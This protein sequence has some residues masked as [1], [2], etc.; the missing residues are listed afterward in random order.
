M[1]ISILEFDEITS[2]SDYLKTNHASLG[3][4]TFVRAQH[5]TSGRGQFKR[6]WE[7]EKGSNLL[8]SV[9]LKP[10]ENVDIHDI[11]NHVL[12]GLLNVLEHHGIM[13]RY[14]APN[15]LYVEHKKI[16]GILIE[17][18]MHGSKPTY[19]VVGIGL[20]VNQ[21][22]F[23]VPNATSMA[24]LKSRTFDVSNIFDQMVSHIT[25]VL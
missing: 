14:K 2:T 16:C 4:L 17:T 20:N 19:V 18:K 9:L 25:S 7:S 21:T 11:K 3:H 22:R 15:D 1:S 6:V 12:I 10:N 23:D 8:F 5:Q 13:A 24:L